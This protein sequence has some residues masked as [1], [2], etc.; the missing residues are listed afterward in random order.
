MSK[1][2]STNPKQD[3]PPLP[4]GLGR[5]VNTFAFP[6]LVADNLK[7]LA[8]LQTPKHPDVARVAKA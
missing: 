2:L 6:T 8:P 5:E 3:Q 1:Q 7:E 4:H